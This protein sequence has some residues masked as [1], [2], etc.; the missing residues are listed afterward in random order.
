ML[1]I[2]VLGFCGAVHLGAGLT[3]GSLAAILG[4]SR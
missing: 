2:A 3:V 1:T 4:V